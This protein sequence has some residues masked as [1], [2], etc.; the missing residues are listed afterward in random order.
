MTIIEDVQRSGQSLWYDN[1]ERSK[2]FDGSIEDMIRTGKIRG[3]TSNPSIFQK[4]I[5]TS[6]DYDVT[7]KPMA[8]AGLDSEEIFWQLAVEDIQKAA[9]LFLPLYEASKGADGFVSLEVNPL[10][11]YDTDRTI[12]EAQKLWQRVKMPNLMIKI[13]ATREGIPAIRKTIAA[14][15]N[16]NVTLIFSIDRYGDVMEAYIAGLEDRVKQGRSIN[17]IASVA[18]FFVSRI[19][20][21]I[22]TKLQELVNKDTLAPDDF[23]KLAGK[24][25]IVNAR[26][27]YR[28]FEEQFTGIRFKIL[29]KQGAHVQRPL[30]ASTSTKNPAYRDVMYVEELIA[31]ESVNTVPP[32]TLEAFLDHGVVEITIRKDIDE[33]QD[34]ITKLEDLGISL[35]QV[36]AE[37]EEEGVKAFSDA[38]TTLLD[39]VEQRRKLAVEEIAPINHAVREK[40][41]E[42]EKSGFSRRLFEKDPSLWSEDLKGQEEIRVRMDWL[43]T[44]YKALEEPPRIQKY[45]KRI[46]CPGIY[47]CRTAGDGGIFIGTRSDEQDTGIVRV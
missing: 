6:N 10:L 17:D 14:G 31:P 35:K 42:L 23:I 24:A 45:W 4:A 22:D 1:I 40:I 44:P 7:L 38:Y 21:K 26:L 41:G 30:W 13:P 34:I 11:A 36:T 5:A 15:I 3:I 9:E 43:E 33:A 2:L 16:V 32:A 37:L 47:Q 27:A 20:T 29:E 46:T 39:T 19:D 18:S 8:W 12:E 25:A 28:K